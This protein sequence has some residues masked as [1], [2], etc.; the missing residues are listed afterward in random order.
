MYMYVWVC[1]R[2]CGSSWP[3]GSFQINVSRMTGKT[4]NRAVYSGIPSVSIP[5]CQ[6]NPLPK[7]IRS[8]QTTRV[9]NSLLSTRSLAQKPERRIWWEWYPGPA[10]RPITCFETHQTTICTSITVQ[11]KRPSAASCLSWKLQSPPSDLEYT[12][13]TLRRV[14]TFQFHKL[15]TATESF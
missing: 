12:W 3:L 8:A 4:S 1:V 14:F 13:N 2:I 6:T 5:K 9:H 7:L 15:L 10:G 11:I